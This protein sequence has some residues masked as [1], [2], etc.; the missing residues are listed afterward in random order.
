ME[1]ALVI[2][3]FLVGIVFIVKG[4][5]YFVDAASWIAE[6]SGIP[7]LIIGATIVSLAT[8]LPEML[9]SVM[10]AAQGKVDMAIGNA[11]GSVTANIG[12]IMAI[13]V[14]CMPGMAKRKDYLRKS[15]LMLAAAVMVVL[16]GFLGRMGTAMAVVMMIIF[17]IFM[18]DNILQAKNSVTT[19]TDSTREI[20]RPRPERRE[21]IINII[22]FVVG[23][24]GIVWGADLLVD[25]GSELARF[26]GISERIIGVT[27]IA[28]GT[29]LPELIT[30]I[31]AIVKK[32]SSLSVGNILGANIID[33]TLIL[34]VSALVSGK[35]LPI[36]SASAMLDL[37]A[38]LLVGGVALIPTM[39]TQKFTRLQGVLLLGIY[40]AYMVLTCAVIGV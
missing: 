35:A 15:V 21:I 34:P 32:E 5:D 25:N 7:K 3:L 36:A 24:V 4:G 33:L 1:L 2:F 16:S 39:F 18:G 9:V 27:V 17:A 37:P 8:T 11:V 20:K 23:T 22:K 30:T 13:S 19:R 14:L 28:V 38:C 6:V 31:T 10:A 29:S 26:I 40:I 12:L